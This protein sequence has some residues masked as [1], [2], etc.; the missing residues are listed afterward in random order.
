LDDEY[1]KKYEN[2]IQN[3]IYFNTNSENPQNEGIR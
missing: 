2:E 3:K 1:F